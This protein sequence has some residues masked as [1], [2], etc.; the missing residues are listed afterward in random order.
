MPPKYEPLAADDGG[1][2]GGPACVRW[3]Q[4]RWWDA[5]YSWVTPLIALGTTRQLRHTDLPELPPKMRIGRAIE[6]LRGGLDGSRLARE[7]EDCLGARTDGP[8]ALFPDGS[9]LGVIFHVYWR[10]QL[11]SL[12]FE[13]CREGCAVLVTVAMRRVILFM[14]D[15]DR[16]PWEGYML[17]SLASFSSCAGSGSLAHRRRF[18]FRAPGP[19]DV[20]RDARPGV[21]HVECKIATL[22]LSAVPSR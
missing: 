13:F 16:P 12:G 18:S 20:P 15:A 19:R 11:Q 1:D 10:Q 3:D 14:E 7:A 9:L 2:D 22:S 6:D 8:K 17:V 21:L 4:A 5:M